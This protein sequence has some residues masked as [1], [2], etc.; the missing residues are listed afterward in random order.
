MLDGH[1]LDF[2]PFFSFLYFC[3]GWLGV[4]VTSMESSGLVVCHSLDFFVAYLAPVVLGANL[5]YEVST[6]SMAY[7]PGDRVS[8]LPGK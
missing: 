8:C 7:V 3:P 2:S 5:A 4:L 1:F 6:T